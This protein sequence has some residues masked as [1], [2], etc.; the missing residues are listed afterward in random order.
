[1]S[2]ATL[3]PQPRSNAIPIADARGYVTIPWT[4]YLAAL[5]ALARLLDGNVLGP[6]TNAANDA[7]AAAAGV[8]INGLYRNGNAVQV[9]LT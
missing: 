9:R 1:M 5:D 4:Q 7:A 3:G 2:T 6:L 8:P